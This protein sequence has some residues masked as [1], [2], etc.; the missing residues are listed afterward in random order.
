MNSG[1]RSRA[2]C[3]CLLVALGA[4]FPSHAWSSSRTFALQRIVS[5]ATP[6]AAN[7][8]HPTV[9]T[10]APDG[11]LFFA[12]D[13]GRIFYATLDANSNVVGSVAD[14]AACLRD[15]LPQSL[16]PAVAQQRRALCERQR[17]EPRRGRLHLWQCHE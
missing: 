4:L 17:P 1:R 10:L 7:F 11:R 3:V 12:Q 9:V 6:G 15:R 5:S 2:V 13:S 16:R 14:C 8:G